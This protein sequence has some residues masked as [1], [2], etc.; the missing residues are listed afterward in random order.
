MRQSVFAVLALVSV[1]SVLACSSAPE[2]LA[3]LSAD[4]GPAPNGSNAPGPNGAPNPDG[5]DGGARQGKPPEPPAP[6]AKAEEVT[7]AFGF[8]VAKSG[9]AENAG[10]R[11]APLASIGDAIVKAKAAK[12]RVFV[13]EGTYEENLELEN[14]VSIVGGLDCSTASWKL[15]EKRSVLKSPVSP[16]IHAVN[17]TSPTRIDQF[18]VEAPDATEAS[19]SSI[20]VLAVDS[21]ALTFAKGSI[22]AGVGMK[23]ENGVEGE[24][25]TLRPQRNAETGQK[26]WQTPTPDHPYH[27]NGGLGAVGQCLHFDGRLFS[28][29]MGDNGGSSGLFYRSGTGVPFAQIDAPRPPSGGM[30]ASDAVNGANGA[31]GVWTAAES[32]FTPGD[33]SA[34]VSGTGGRAGG[35]GAGSAP[36]PTGGLGR[37]WGDSGPGGG[38]GGCPGLAGTPGKGGGASLGVLAIRSP[39]RLD[40][41]T[42]ASSAGGAGGSGTFGSAPT[43][44]TGGGDDNP[45]PFTL[46]RTKSS[47]GG[48]GGTSGISGN[49]AGGPSIA[50]AHQGG[51]PILTQSNTK[52]GAGGAGVEA[53]SQGGKTLP[54]SPA[55][56][57]EGVKAL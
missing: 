21:N 5:A 43:P 34:G 15:T 6:P 51:A 24:L 19:G 54:A 56:E 4:G 41:I 2:T 20:G 32:G 27:Q 29:Q 9:S 40:G 23:G 45:N 11:E 53:R 14:G 3:P 31:T 50:I 55:G 57:S 52:V 16:A 46:N 17:V 48:L 8:F 49:G 44:G 25:L 12:K 35:G 13:C 42:I 22:K 38:L 1:S 37:W 28:T 39:V 30:P 10:T 7:E 36:T 33:G 26:G 18:D 47:P